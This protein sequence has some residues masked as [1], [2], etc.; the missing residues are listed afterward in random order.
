MSGMFGNRQNKLTVASV[1][2]LREQ[3][4]HTLREIFSQEQR[5]DKINGSD[6][7]ERQKGNKAR[8][9]ER[10][11]CLRNWAFFRAT[12]PPIFLQNSCRHPTTSPL[13]ERIRLRRQAAQGARWSV[14][15]QQNSLDFAG[16]DPKTR[17][18][19]SGVPTCMMT[20]PRF[21]CIKFS[22]TYYVFK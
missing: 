6:R 9:R 10:R 14:L 5:A 22:T 8:R 17:F 16:R 15:L 19:Q 20:M 11:W 4:S 13:N 1:R 18:V 21:F 12:R 2:Q 3:I 7:E